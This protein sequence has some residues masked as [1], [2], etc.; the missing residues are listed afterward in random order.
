MRKFLFIICIFVCILG[1][2]FVGNTIISVSHAPYAEY[3]SLTLLDKN[4]VKLTEK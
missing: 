2:F 1:V 3:G 4:G